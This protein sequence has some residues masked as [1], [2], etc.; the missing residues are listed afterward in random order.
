M[1]QERPWPLFQWGFAWTS[2]VLSWAKFKDVCFDETSALNF[3]DSLWATE[4]PIFFY[5]THE[6]FWDPLIAAEI[7]VLRCKRQCVAPMAQ[8]QLDRFPSLKRVGVFGVRAHAASEI[9]HY[10]DDH[11]RRVR[12][13]AVWV[14]PQAA[15]VP[16]SLE[17]PPFRLGLSMWSLKRNCVRIPVVIRFEGD[18]KPVVRLRLGNP[19][20]VQGRSIVFER[21]KA[22]L[23]EDAERLREN[24][25]HEVRLSHESE[26]WT[27]LWPFSESVRMVQ[28]RGA[29]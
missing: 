14:T 4:K 20:E 10:I 12:H 27:S 15:F 2:R 17:Q 18:E 6:S 16:N 24:L 28:R 1:I 19:E 13:P 26:S 8:E 3:G 25:I 9:D 11:I 22:L 21:D 23:V 29:L 5:S 7:A